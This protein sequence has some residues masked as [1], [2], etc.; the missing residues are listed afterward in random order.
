MDTYIA[1]SPTINVRMT[2]E[3][4]SSIFAAE[5]KGH[6]CAQGGGTWVQGYLLCVRIYC[7][8]QSFPGSSGLVY[9]GYLNSGDNREIVAIKTCKGI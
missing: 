8:T 3:L 6:V 4:S 7:T 5:F 1:G 9:R 2:F